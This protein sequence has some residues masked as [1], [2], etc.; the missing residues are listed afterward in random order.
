M[1]DSLLRNI[2][3]AALAGLAGCSTPVMS[4]KPIITAATMQGPLAQSPRGTRL[5]FDGEFFL[6]TKQSENPL[7]R[8]RLVS[9]GAEGGTVIQHL[10]TKHYVQAL[11]GEFF[12]SDELGTNRL[13]LVSASKETQQ[14]WFSY[15][16]TEWR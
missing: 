10:D 14:A 8:V 13:K 7:A 11:P 9:I 2:F 6:S 15:R 1:T 12:V 4:P 3:L 5:D 16:W